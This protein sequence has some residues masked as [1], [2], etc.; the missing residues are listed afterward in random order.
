MPRTK[1]AGTAETPKTG[2][3]EATA[4]SN[5][6]GRVEWAKHTEW[7]DRLVAKFLEDP[8]LCARLFSDSI[9]AAKGEGRQK[10]TSNGSTKKDLHLACAAAVW[11]IPEEPERASYLQN[12]GKYATAVDG[13]IKKWVY[14][15]C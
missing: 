6:S 11:D 3:T 5:I 7:T 4:A 1:K 8:T 2:T 12:P 13:R 15:A 14:V 9:E 10:I